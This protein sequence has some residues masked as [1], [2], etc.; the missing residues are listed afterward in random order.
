MVWFLSVVENWHVFLRFALIKVLYLM[1]VTLIC[2]CN[3]DGHT[4]Y[5]CYTHFE[6]HD[7][8]QLHRNLGYLQGG[9]TEFL[10]LPRGPADISPKNTHLLCPFS[11]Q[12][13]LETIYCLCRHRIIIQHIP[14][15]HQYTTRW[16]KKYFLIS[17]LHRHLTSFSE[18]PRPCCINL[19][20]IC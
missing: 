8:L 2:L 19:K 7:V 17:L 6:T 16:E 12:F 15:G 5:L 11:F 9:R 20:H 3:C 4:P 10:L 1:P 14:L 18:C 13:S